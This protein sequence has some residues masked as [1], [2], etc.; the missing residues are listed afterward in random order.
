M[1][2]DILNK[3]RKKE[4]FQKALYVIDMNNGFVNF[5]AMHNKSYNDLVPSQCDLINKFRQEN[6]QVN[7]ILEGHDKDALEFASYPEHCV[8]GTPEAEL[9]DELLPEQGKDNTNSFYKNSINGM[10]N[11]NL[12]EEIKRLKKLREIVIVGVCADLCVMDFARSY[13]RYLD[14]INKDAH[15]FAVNNAID[16]FDAP[17]HDRVEWLNI[18]KQV[19]M[20]AGIEFVNNREELETRERELGL[21]LKNGG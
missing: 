7:F 19:M 18:A 9:I 5:G 20:Q 10:L 14:E 1:E 4:E 12:H 17:G 11:T 8:Y 2:K 13:A 21:Y 15:I 6:Q 3:G 16:T